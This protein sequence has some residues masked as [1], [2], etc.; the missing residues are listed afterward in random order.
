MIQDRLAVLAAGLVF[1][2]GKDLRMK[3]LRRLK[4]G[5]TCGLFCLV[6]FV[7][8]AGPAWSQ[9]P[10][11]EGKG[12][13]IM[14]VACTV[15]HGLDYITHGRKSKEGWHSIVMEMIGYGAVLDEKEIT[16][17][18]EYLAQQF[19]SAKAAESSSTGIT[20][21]P[22]GAQ[23]SQ[24]GS[25]MGA[26]SSSTGITIPGGAQAPQFDPVTDAVLQNPDPADWLQWRRD[27][28]ATGYSP[29]DQV[30]RQ[31]VA[32]LRLAWAWAMEDGEAEA[33]P[34]VHQGVMYLP[35]N[36][37]VV[38]ALDARTGTLI[39]EYRHRTLPVGLGPRDRM[40]NIAIYQDKIY[41][42]TQD[43]YLMALDAMTG[44]A[45]WETKVGAPE[46]R[47]DY[48]SGPM[49]AEGKVFSGTTSC[50][51][52]GSTSCFVSA[53][54]A[55]TGKEL[56]RRYSVA[57][58][59][60]PEAHQA[61]WGGLPY[62]KRVHSSF[63]LTGSYDPGLKLV[64]WNSSVPRPFPEI[65]RGS[66]SGAALYT[67]SILALNP[68]TGAIKWFFQMLPRDNNDMDHM[69]NPILAD[70]EVGGVRRKVVYSL[71]K[72]GMLWAFDRESGAYLWNRQLVT[73]QNLYKQIDP[74]SGAITLNEEVIPR[75]IGD[76]RLVCP[77]VRGGKL[78]QTKAYNPRTNM[79]Y[80]PVS[81][82]CT[83]NKVVPLEV[84]S[85]GIVWTR[86]VHMDG[87]GEKAGRLAAV[88]ASSGELLWTYD[89][90]AA[91]GSV[92]TTAGGLVFAGDFYRYFRALDAETGKVLWEIPLSG[93]VTGY[94][95]IY[96]V[97]VKQYV[98]VAVGGG[99][100][101]QPH[102]GQLY[103]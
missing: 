17:L 46:K 37:G 5:R 93:P 19:G 9:T 10:L 69:D 71:G 61:T 38:Q 56:W 47:I 36:R 7:G 45:V 66:G 39:W 103:P 20:I 58:P 63:W 21:P 32:K 31:N 25:A 1:L 95:I 102:L 86:M 3:Y 70:V 60:D 65:H 59:G 91:I 11:P 12:K 92:L 49:A 77:G 18:V 85:H 27:Q 100:E 73:Y 94:P 98:A 50:S 34:I 55:A 40:R 90:R 44:K 2:T 72:P 23:A 30:N 62:E 24:F 97:G 84:R 75:K 33:E 43:G 76:S 6:F 16:V 26:E 101:G 8:M 22:G 82:S 54:D 68:E 48:T 28:S 96:A 81:N 53:H 74:K 42:G 15:C 67:N 35:N 14:E 64:Y 41:L 79:L 99:T 29:L 80:S 83:I 4:C 52:P 88:S 89:Q 13:E 51:G 87:S 57:G 78:F